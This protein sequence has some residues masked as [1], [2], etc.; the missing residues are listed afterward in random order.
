VTAQLRLT[1]LT[2][3]DKW[4]LEQALACADPVFEPRTAPAS[5]HGELV[6]TVLTVAVSAAAIRGLVTW[7][8]KN[9]RRETFRREIE[10]VRPDGTVQRETIVIDVHESITDPEVVRQL[11]EALKLDAS[12]IEAA[13]G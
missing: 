3:L 11:G 9:R 1:D 2:A 6:T 4:E 8:S 7:I 12:I 10:I 13:A 5:A